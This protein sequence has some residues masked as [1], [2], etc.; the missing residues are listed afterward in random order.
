MAHACILPLF[1]LSYICIQFWFQTN[2]WFW[3]VF[4]TNKKT[5]SIRLILYPNSHAQYC[6]WDKNVVENLG[7]NGYLLR[8]AQQARRAYSIFGVTIRKRELGAL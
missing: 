3:F 7:R 1:P 8:S 4:W 5:E 6:G 2:F